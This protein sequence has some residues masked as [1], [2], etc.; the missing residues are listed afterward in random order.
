MSRPTGLGGGEYGCV[1]LRFENHKYLRFATSFL[2]L[3]GNL[4]RVNRFF[5]ICVCDNIMY[6][7]NT[8]KMMGMLHKVSRDSPGRILH[9]SRA[10]TF[11][12]VFVAGLF[13]PKPQLKKSVTIYHYSKIKILI[14][15]LFLIKGTVLRD[16]RQILPTTKR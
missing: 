14:S 3:G 2:T 5:S 10:S 4:L 12:V 6:N 11:F 16:R 7:T 8:Q 15:P 1:I 9:A 13:C